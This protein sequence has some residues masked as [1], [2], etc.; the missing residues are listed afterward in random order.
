MRASTAEEG[1]SIGQ[2][3]VDSGLDAD[4]VGADGASSSGSLSASAEAKEGDSGSE[5]ST[6]TGTGGATPEDGADLTLSGAGEPQ[7]SYVQ[8]GASSS[9]VRHSECTREFKSSVPS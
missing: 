2:D 1:G 9:P 7:G 6:S 8:V 5:E 3:V 4:G